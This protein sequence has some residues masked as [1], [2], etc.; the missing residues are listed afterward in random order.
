MIAAAVVF[1][2]EAGAT[3]QVADVLTFERGRGWIQLLGMPIHRYRKL[4]PS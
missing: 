3:I 4:R 1:P 2:V